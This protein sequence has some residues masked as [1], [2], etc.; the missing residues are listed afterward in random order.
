[1]EIKETPIKGLIE[2]VPRIFEDER[3]M[4]FESF[5]EKHL[6]EAGIN[7]KFVQDNQSFSTGGVLRGLHLQTAPFAQGKLV[8]V[9]TGSVMD[10]AVDLRQDSPTFGE[11][12]SIVLDAKRNNMLFIPE[13]FAHGFLALEDTVFFYKCTNYYNKASEAGI[14]WNDATLN[15]KWPIE[16]PIVSE[17]DAILPTFQEF[18]KLHGNLVHSTK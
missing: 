3:G 16:N 6:Q 7:K 13:G 5:H 14:V 18:L 2:L 9:I 4:F 1:M 15:I 17:K 12:W 10:V 8:R 11:H